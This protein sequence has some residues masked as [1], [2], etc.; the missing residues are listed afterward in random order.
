[1]QHTYT[2]LILHTLIIDKKWHFRWSLLIS[3]ARIKFGS[4]LHKSERRKHLDLPQFS[5]SE[6]MKIFRSCVHLLDDSFSV[7]VVKDLKLNHLF[8]ADDVLLF[9]KGDKASISHIMAS[10]DLFS[11][12]S[13]L[14]PSI[15]KS[16]SF[17]VNCDDSVQAWFDDTYGVPK[18]ELPVK[19]LGV[20][21]I[22]AELSINHCMPLIQKIVQR[23]ESWTALLLSFAGRV[24]LIKAVLFAIQAYWTRHF[25]LP[26]AIH[27]KLQQMFTR[28]LW[29]GDHTKTGGA[30]VSWAAV[31]K[32]WEEGGLGLKNLVEWNST[33]L[34]MHFWR[35]VKRHHFLWI[36][37]V[38]STVLKHKNF[39]TMIIPTDCSWFW[40]NIL[41]L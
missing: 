3:S 29:K 14:L 17:L 39:W 34:L 36:S 30:K 12:L 11:K 15:H 21:L 8:F 38:F 19:F 18:G 32:P 33:Q 28:F 27:K 26:V 7:S 1:M 41:K 22:S 5:I 9:S 6:K 37:W 24:Q 13:G 20:P 16:T 31:C 35:L 40:R 25:M 10:L 4:I 2:D 23:I